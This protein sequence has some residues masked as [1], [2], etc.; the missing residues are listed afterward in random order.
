MLLG[1]GRGN[2]SA[3]AGSIKFGYNN[4]ADGTSLD[5]E[6]ARFGST[7]NFAL[8]GTNTS[9]YATQANFFIG[10][11][12]DIYADTGTGSGKSLSISNNAY[13]NA[14]GNWVYRATD[15]ASNLYQYDGYIGFRT[16]ASGT[17]GNTI[18]WSEKLR[19]A[20]DG[21]ITNTGSNS[22]PTS[23]SGF[24][25]TQDQL[26]LS[27]AGTSANYAL[28]SVSYTHLTLPTILLV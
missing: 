1:T 27:T 3:T 20:N 4:G 12:G 24:G 26:Y 9:G 22:A 10:G 2:S 13:I 25:F 15:K 18:S 19:I 21:T 8:G 23:G 16:V 17:A 28:R 6:F 11:V 14:A 7:G 5:S